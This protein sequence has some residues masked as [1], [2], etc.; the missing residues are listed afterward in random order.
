MVTEIGAEGQRSG[1]SYDPTL[2]IGGFSQ[3]GDHGFGAC[4]VGANA[5]ALGAREAVVVFDI[6]P[7]DSITER[8]EVG[9]QGRFGGVTASG[10]YSGNSY[11]SDNA[12]DY[13]DDD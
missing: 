1:I 7:I 4:G 10:G 13:D 11:G 5:V 12:Q 3:L 9:A 2:G 8:S 6:I